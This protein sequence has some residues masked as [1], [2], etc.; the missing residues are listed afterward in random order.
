[1]I[2]TMSMPVFSQQTCEC[3]TGLTADLKFFTYQMRLVNPVISNVR[4][5]VNDTNTA[6][7][8][9]TEPSTKTVYKLMCKYLEGCSAQ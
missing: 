8:T 1:M 4:P 3:E 6:Y 7:A 9:V 5:D 2:L